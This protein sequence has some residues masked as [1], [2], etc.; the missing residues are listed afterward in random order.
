MFSQYSREHLRLLLD[1]DYGGA[2]SVPH[3]APDPQAKEYG[4]VRPPPPP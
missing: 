4:L 1:T 2:S 3:L